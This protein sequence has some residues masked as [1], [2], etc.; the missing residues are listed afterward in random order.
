[1]LNIMQFFC[2]FWSSKKI[3]KSRKVIT[4]SNP[5]EGSKKLQEEV[6]E[7]S[8]MIQKRITRGWIKTKEPLE[9]LTQ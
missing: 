7:E 8:E 5:Q 3:T 4:I 1:M 2:C 9:T 6:Y